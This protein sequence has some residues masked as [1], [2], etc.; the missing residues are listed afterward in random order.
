M[1]KEQSVSL[2]QQNKLP[3]EQESFVGTMLC[4]LSVYKS[5]TKLTVER[6][7]LSF[8][9]KDKTEAKELTELAIV[10]RAR[11]LAQGSG[12]VRQKYDQ[13]VDLYK[14][15]VNL[16][17][18]TSTSML[19]QQ[20][21]TPAPI[22]FLMGI[23]VKLDKL[24]QTD[25]YG[26][27][28]SA[29]NGLLT[30]AGPPERITVNEVDEI[31][32]RNLETQG[33]RL[34]TAKDASEPFHTLKDT[35][36]AVVTN[37]PFG[38]LRKSVYFDT[39][40]VDTLDGLMALRAL[41][42]MKPDGRAAVIMGGHTR[43][44]YRGRIQG[45]RNRIFFNYIYS[46]YY[47][48]DVI[49]I[50]GRTLFSR[51]GTSFNTR[52]ILIA[53]RKPMPEGIA[54]L[55]DPQKDNVAGTFDQLY[56]RIITA[57]D[58][59]TKLKP[60]KAECSRSDLHERYSR[61]QEIERL[62]E[63]APR[64]KQFLIHNDGT[65]YEV[66]GIN[67]PVIC[68]RFR[69]K[70]TVRFLFDRQVIPML[71]IPADRVASIKEKL[72]AEGYVIPVYDD[73]Y[74][75]VPSAIEL[76]ELEDKA[77]AFLKMLEDEGL[78]APYQP[79]SDA[80]VVLDTQVPDSMAFETH[81]A[82]ALIEREV[83]GDIDNF[84]RDRLGYHSKLEMCRALS[85]EQIDAVAMAIYNIEARGQGM[86][87]GDQTGIG[88]GRIAAS[89]IRYA[90]KQ[91]LHPVFITEKANLFSDI[92]RDLAAIGSSHLRPFIVNARE[93]KSDIKDEDGT[94]IYQAP[95]LAE[96]QTIFA[97]QQLPIHFDFICATYSQFNSAE[98]KPL[99]PYF[100]KA[101]AQDN[102]FIMDE[103]HN[104][105]GSSNTGIFLQD[106]VG[107]T[108]GVAF[109]SA[110]FAKRPDNMPIYAMRTAIS[111]SN[112][113]SYSLVNSIKRGG[114]ALQEILAAQLVQEG[115]MLR[116]ERSY[117]GVEVNYISLDDR[118]AEHTAISDN[119]TLVMRD[120]ISFQ[121]DHIEKEIVAMDEQAAK[122]MQEVEVREGTSQAGVDN[123]PYFSKIFQVINQMLF[124]LKAEAVADRAI[125][126][127]KE[128]KKPVIAF[129]STMGSF[130]EDLI[131][132][133]T[134]AGEE[135]IIS[136]DFSQVLRKGL[137]GVLRY[138][139][140]EPDGTS[141]Y[142]F[143]EVSELPLLAQIEYKR[144]ETLISSVST[145][146]TISPL[147]VIVSRIRAAG[148]SVIEVT[149]RKYE[150]QLNDTGTRGI[151]KTRRKVNTN[152]AFR[153]FN[154]NE[155]DVLLINQAGSTGASAHAIST[156]K[157]PAEDVKQRVMIVLQA[158][159]DINT[160]VQK[161]GRVNR[162]G[163]LFKPIYDYMISAIPAEK[164]MMMILQKKLKSLDA[165]TTSN[166]KQSNRILDVPDFLNKYGDDVVME[167]LKDHPEIDKL[168][169]YPA[170]LQKRNG[171]PHDTVKEDVSLKA[172]GRVAVLSTKM[173]K[174]FY[175]EIAALY[176]EHISYLKQTG[177]YDLEVE[178]MNL[179]AKTIASNIMRMG[180]G[181][182]SVFGQ[183]SVL[184]K[185]EVNVLRK[186]F[187]PTELN[188]IL[189]ESLAGRT[190]NEVRSE[191]KDEFLK[192]SHIL[193]E[194]ER[195]AVKE[196]FDKL[197]SNIQG[198]RSIRKLAE[199]M[200]EW[201]L[202]ISKREKEL[203]EEKQ[204]KLSL[205]EKKA[206]DRKFY[207]GKV[208]PFF[209][210]GQ[211]LY[212]PLPGFVRETELV[213]AVFLGYQ[214]DWKKQNPF[215]PSAIKLRFA[216]ANSNKYI[217]I[218]ASNKAVVMAIMGAGEQNGIAD[219][220]ALLDRWMDWTSQSSTDRQ[221]RYIITGNL[222]QAFADQPGKLISYTTD[223]NQVKKGILLSEYWDPKEQLQD[224]VAVPFIKA[225][226]LLQSLTAGNSMKTSTGISFL[227]VDG[228]RF[229]IIVAASRA[230]NGETFLNAEVL[231]LVEG[232]NFEK[233][234]D[235]MVAFVSLDNLAGLVAVIQKVS[236]CSTD[237]HNSQL[238][239]IKGDIVFAERTAIRLPDPEP[240]PSTDEDEAL[241]ILELEAEAAMATIIIE[242]ELYRRRA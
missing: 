197:T 69:L 56:E 85:A 63:I 44:D 207:L 176:E 70:Q 200:E 65:H 57:M 202:A 226:P 35:F 52:I 151:I 111:D 119:I 184:E 47:V 98:K 100:L 12:S 113:D 102:I 222:L 181:G 30:I 64:H 231:E 159:L 108:R 26:F 212:Y 3:A 125:M 112:L 174:V 1:E 138:T 46:R 171:E 160:E 149:G 130:V 19:L 115:Q 48:L 239:H 109:L 93:S 122:A 204:Q 143:L 27:E 146:I 158:E 147:D 195:Q 241:T 209:Y 211:S 137:E 218:P 83:G 121:A 233:R 72:T 62:Y 133:A 188:N 88:K 225:L 107:L 75:R 187:T 117:E 51:Q 116:R 29:G 22:G 213:P 39:Y 144:I 53:G 201:Q 234:A 223:N 76:Q 50:N 168:L 154:N 2:P 32:R 89:V 170:R 185:V 67:V 238:K 219:R 156:A 131:A 134:P 205:I 95:P 13:I 206:S 242:L 58:M 6:L 199:N 177:E 163:Q 80:C 230:A 169:N 20:Y 54:S 235:K 31:R 94:V 21:S 142:G 190:P 91:G 10:R 42:T 37:P 8:G 153:M 162:T 17:H 33:Y 237:I 16:S 126:R 66:Y 92:Y 9:I 191:L 173:Q 4:D 139:V 45:G 216:L 78:G 71:R 114:V 11:A 175:D 110:T 229:K 106:V 14:S 103:A 221:I 99:K 79:A 128:G 84:V 87:I 120:I 192:Y 135:T 180:K 161:R 227:R 101:I 97:H 240:G 150:L 152:D 198:E 232:N 104:S 179:E 82:I 167:F 68:R 40:K 165:N 74:P 59:A 73:T 60:L 34:T 166:Q 5:H 164:R 24:E 155:A 178:A 43:W 18:R 189:T 193:F 7:A 25:G 23:F 61:Y 129:S 123:E 145:G 157:V 236:N 194:E 140:K 49:N 77:T 217:V 208:L 90:C 38:T 183:D 182:Q 136:T 172:S 41:E 118:E 196:Q 186:P 127:L 105:S 124:S 210:I 55:Y 220:F 224:K 215:A 15:Q 148:Y 86:I 203:E 214:M 36:Q 141:S 96:Q 28:P 132:Q 81:E 228:Q